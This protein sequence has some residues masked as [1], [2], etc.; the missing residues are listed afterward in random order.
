MALSPWIVGGERRNEGTV[1][2]WIRARDIGFT[3]LIWLA[4]IFI[5]FWLVGHVSTAV[6]IFAVAALLAYA[7]L[8]GVTLLNR[9]LPRS[10]AAVIVYILALAVLGGLGYLIVSTAISQLVELVKS[11]PGLLQPGT[12]GHPSA[13]ARLLSP[14]GITDAQINAAR[15]EIISQIESSA[16][17]II[18]GAVPIVTGVANGIINAVLVF[19]LSL[20][21]AIDGPRLFAWLGSAAPIRQRTRTWFLL[22]VL[23]RT[24]GGYIRGQLFMSTFIGVLVGAGMFAFRVPYALLLGVLAFLLEFVPIIGTIISGVACVLIAL[25]SK[26]FIIALLV[27]AYF[28]IVHI[29]EGDVVGPRVMGR[30][31]GL[32]PVVAILAL[33]VGTEL[34]GTWG[35]IFGAPTVGLIQRVLTTFWREWRV[36]HPEQFPEERHKDDEAGPPGGRLEPQGHETEPMAAPAEKPGPSG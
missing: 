18:G 34:F 22:N 12:P 8:P 10:L 15:Q 24:V 1:D 33:V 32:H 3:I 6:L 20:Y 9:W 7:L 30:V 31:L 35:A 27:L 19:I 5:V 2:R 4:V 11:L 23:R 17:Q 28:V 29:L 21:L 26:G 13:L 25:T 36:A 14:L 16:G